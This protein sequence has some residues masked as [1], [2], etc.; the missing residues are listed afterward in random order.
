MIRPKLSSVQLILLVSAVIVLI[1]NNVFFSTLTQRLNIYSISGAGYVVT[2]YLLIVAIVGLL[3][4]L[5]AQIYLLKPMLVML[6][7]L[8]AIIS[9]F[10]KE[11][12]VIFDVDMMRNIFETVKDNNRKE[13]LELISLPLIF[14]ISIFGILPSAFVLFVKINYKKGMSELWSRSGYGLMT[15]SIV[16]LMV[17]MNFKYATYFSRENRDLRVWVTPVFPM[18]SLFKYL[19]ENYQGSVAPFRRLGTDARQEKLS[20]KRTVGIL[21]LGETAREDHFSL[22][23]YALKTNPL[24]EKENILSFHNVSSCGTSTAFSV[25]CMFSLL[26][27]K[28]YTPTKAENQSNVLDVLKK[29][30]VETF[31][32]DNNSSCKGVCARIETRVIRHHLDPASQ[33][34]N[35]GEYY[36]GRLLEEMLP[37]IESNQVDT[38]IVL[39]TLG[40]HGPAYYRRF[41]EEFAKFTPYCKKKSPQECPDKELSNAYDNSLLYTDYI[42]SQAIAFLKQ[43]A[44]QYDSFLVYV[45]DHGESLGENGIYLHGL[46]YLIAPKAQTHIPLLVWFSNDFPNHHNIDMDAL[47][48]RADRPYSHDNLS[49]SLLG[50]FNVKSDVYQEGA[51]MFRL[52]S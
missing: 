36:D 1:D 29:A 5:V 31:W 41:P 17:L 25:P 45:S 27:R 14:H 2:F 8:S 34:Y 42:L 10:N 44:D 47:R 48:G 3:F 43:H 12:G 24:L 50:L 22:D 15:I 6:L 52:G 23:G 46:P 21:V 28:N 51:D 26:D 39:H 32:I 18:L 38:L 11:L 16:A 20:N 33:Y 19:A 7:I 35:K 49:H 40:S 13:G 4:L 37:Y 30:G 9:Y